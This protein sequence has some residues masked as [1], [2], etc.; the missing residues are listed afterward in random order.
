MKRTLSAFAEAGLVLDAVIF[1]PEGSI[2]A[3]GRVENE[4]DDTFL[5]PSGVWPTDHKGLLVTFGM[6]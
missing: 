5:L 2:A 6:K 1:G 4:S 3:S